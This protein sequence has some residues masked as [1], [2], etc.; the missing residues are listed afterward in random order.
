MKFRALLIFFLLNSFSAFAQHS[1]AAAPDSI[2]SYSVT[3]NAHS[4]ILL[5][6]YGFI[7]YLSNDYAHGFEAN[8]CRQTSGKTIWERLYRYPSFGLS[9]FYSSMGNREVF[10]NQYTLYPYYKIHLLEKD[11]FRLS[12]QMGVGASWSTKKFDATDNY[13]NLA[14]GSHLNIHY[15]ADFIAA[16]RTGKKTRI[17][18]GLSFN[19]ISNANLSEPNVGLNFCTLF[20]GLSFDAGKRSLRNRDAVPPFSPYFTYEILAC[21]GMK[22][23][24]TFES[25]RYPAVSLSFEAKRRMRYKFSLGAGADFFYDSSVE[26]QLV[27]TG[28]SFHKSDAFMTGIHVSEE[29]HFNRASL[30]LQEGVYIGLTEKLYGYFMYNRAIARYKVSSHFFVNLSMKSHLYVLDFPELGVGYYW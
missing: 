8:I 19:H 17:N 11:R 3:V 15:H 12:Y 5:P 10:G 28:R 23:T 22:H 2:Y 20:T 4:G 25:F 16:F 13:Q 30:I 26:P 27:R 21:G 6:E 1:D 29:F 24:R 9:F 7:A 14:I 18:A